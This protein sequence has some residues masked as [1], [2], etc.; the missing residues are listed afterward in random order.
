MYV[1]PS[2]MACL[3]SEENDIASSLFKTQD[4]F[5]NRNKNFEIL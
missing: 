3:L 5:R 4:H 2:E 1:P